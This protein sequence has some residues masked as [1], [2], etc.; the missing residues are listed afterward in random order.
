VAVWPCVRHSMGMSA[1][2]P[3]RRVISAITWSMAGSTCGK[4]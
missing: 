2:S 3:A 1:Y 4:A